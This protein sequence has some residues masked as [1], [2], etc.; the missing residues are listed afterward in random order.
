[1]THPLQEPAYASKPLSYWLKIIRN[2]DETM[3]SLAFDAVRNLG[4][5][6]GAAVP[7]LTRVIAAQFTPIRIGKDSQEAIATKVI[8]I[9]IRGEAIDTLAMIG[10]SAATSTL[11]LIRWAL[12]PR[13]VA[14]ISSNADDDELF[15][16]LVMMDTEQ[17]M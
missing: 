13:V 12:T 6:A 2:R 4:P 9:E 14:G 5:D 15:I 8:D 7:E 16:E 10:E 17:R 1:K 3:L 11:P